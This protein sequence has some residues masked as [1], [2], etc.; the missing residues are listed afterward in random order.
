[1][2]L[3]QLIPQDAILQ[4]RKLDWLVS[5]RVDDLVAIMSDNATFVRLPTL[6]S[7]T[8]IIT[9]YGD[10]AVNVSRTI[11]SIMQLVCFIPHVTFCTRLT[12]LPQACAYYWVGFWLLPL[13]YN[14]LLPP[15]P[16]PHQ[17]VQPFM[18]QI[19]SN[20]GAEITFKDNYFEIH[21]TENEVR[22][23]VAFLMDQ[24]ILKVLNFASI[25]P[26]FKPHAAVPLR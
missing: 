24:E 4:P 17:A 7:S 5:D 18:I 2:Q 3:K 12:W 22:S 13:Q 25:D 14:V 15:A 26:V 11:R 16:L 20:F 6:G 21:G 10:H 9:V 19:S 8:S 1:M 23:A